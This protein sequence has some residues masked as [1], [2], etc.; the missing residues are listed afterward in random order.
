MNEEL[1][2]VNETKLLGTIITD[3]ITWD[4]NTEDLK[5]KAFKRMQLLNAAAGFTSKEMI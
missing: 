4:R 3:Q 2:M 1:E 5:K